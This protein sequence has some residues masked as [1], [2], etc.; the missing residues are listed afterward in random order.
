MSMEQ[1]AA[2]LFTFYDDATGERVGLTAAQL[3]GWSAAVASLLTEE[4]GLGPGSRA[5]VLLPPHWQTAAV[6]L[7]AW[8]AGLEVS[9][10][11]WS[12]AGLSENGT[13]GGGS[14]LDVTFVEQRRVG[15]WLDEVPP[16][17]HRFVLG[18]GANGAPACDVPEGYRDFPPAVRAHLGAARPRDRAAVLDAATPD[19]TTFGE[20][21]A[22]AAA[23]A[24]SRGIERGDRVLI[25]AAGSEEPLIWL[26][27]P[28]TAGA[29]VVLCAGLDRS[30]LDERVAAEGVTRMF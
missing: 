27:A 9:F 29:S 28:L 11:G 25:D 13:G 12:T 15:S 22:T 24:R 4:C 2:E 20:Y 8:S 18:L 5:G 19:G 10:R 26:L 17:K 1:R 6:L 23:V 21:G 7:G 30:R 14:R 3:G 16:A